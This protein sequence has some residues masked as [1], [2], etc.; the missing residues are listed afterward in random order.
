V[1]VDKTGPPNALHIKDVPVPT[2]ALVGDAE[3][4]GKA[5]GRLNA[6]IGSRTIP[7]RTQV[8][9]F[10][11]AAEAHR[12]IEEGHVAGKDRIAHRFVVRARTAGPSTA[13]RSGRDDE[14]EG[15]AFD[16][17]LMLVERTADPSASLGMTKGRLVL[18]SA[19]D[20]G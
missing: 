15:S 18:S 4:S 13:L 16:L 14:G 19:P 8:Y 7:L 10:K 9:A 12:R 1:V 5:M 6:A 17:D 20:A 2:L 3:M 11:D